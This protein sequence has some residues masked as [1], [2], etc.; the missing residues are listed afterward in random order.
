MDRVFFFELKPLNEI[1]RKEKIISDIKY[2]NINI[3]NYILW[4]TFSWDRGILKY[5]VEKGAGNLMPLIIKIMRILFKIT[6]FKETY[7]K[8]DFY[9]NNTL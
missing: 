4:I 5:F 7:F 8:I 3:L 1:F 2:F 6:D 9:L